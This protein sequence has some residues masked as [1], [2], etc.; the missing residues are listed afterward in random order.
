MRAVAVLVVL[1]A[2]QGPEIEVWGDPAP[3]VP[4]G[5][6]TERVE[7]S[8]A[9][10]TAHIDVDAASNRL[11]YAF[12][13]D[14][15][16]AY[17]DLH[18]PDL[19][20]DAFFS[21]LP[22]DPEH[23][24]D[25]PI[26]GPWTLDYLALTKRAVPT[27][28]VFQHTRDDTPERGTL[29]VQVVFTAPFEDDR[30]VQDDVREAVG[31]WADTWAEQGI[32]VDAYYQQSTLRGRCRLELGRNPDHEVVVAAGADHDLTILIC[33]GFANL[34]GEAVGFS[35]PNSHSPAMGVIGIVPIGAGP[36]VVAQTLAHETGHAAGL[37]HVEDDALS[38]TPPCPA[39]TPFCDLLGHNFMYSSAICGGATL[40]E[41]DRLTDSGCWRQDEMSPLQRRTLLDWIA[42]R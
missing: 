9:H 14:G 16:D 19:P 11:A 25:L 35:F 15:M 17:A 12:A 21:H 13:S 34:G 39:D 42:I 10:P 6:V 22:D 32:T 3:P 37:A 26:G 5:F 30:A 36:E 23:P 41:P 33:T 7:L 24:S 1:S 31:L 2:C 4:D 18:H 8:E 28:V 27:E 38:D 29:T 20:D 40:T